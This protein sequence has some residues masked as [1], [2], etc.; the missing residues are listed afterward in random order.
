MYAFVFSLTLPSKCEVLEARILSIT[1][2]DRPSTGNSARPLVS[3]RVAEF[4]L[5][6]ESRNQEK[7]RTPEK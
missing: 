2:S 4:K 3:G 6:Q 5:G 1:V 7:L